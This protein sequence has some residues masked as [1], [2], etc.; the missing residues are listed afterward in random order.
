MVKEAHESADV[1][2]YEGKILVILNKKEVTKY[3]I[4][5]NIC[6]RMKA[7]HQRPARL[8]QPLKVP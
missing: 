4:A 2:G 5:Y 1:A 8:L 6:H 7:E 3:V